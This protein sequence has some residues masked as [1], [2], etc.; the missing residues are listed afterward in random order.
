MLFH[1]LAT[2]LKTLA[3]CQAINLDIQISM[4]PQIIKYEMLCCTH[5]Q[6]QDSR[7]SEKNP[8]WI[9]LTIRCTGMSYTCTH[10]SP[11]LTYKP[12]LGSVGSLACY[13]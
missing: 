12:V 1:S 5:M 10:D 13:T 9:S 4:I 6:A 7:E 3:L 8:P 2:I 11:S